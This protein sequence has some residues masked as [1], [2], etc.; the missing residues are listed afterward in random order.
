MNAEKLLTKLV[1]FINSQ[2]EKTDEEMRELRKK[3]ALL[4]SMPFLERVEYLQAVAEAKGKI[5]LLVGQKKFYDSI[6]SNA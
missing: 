2:T 6:S 4:E 5:D 1:S 3:E